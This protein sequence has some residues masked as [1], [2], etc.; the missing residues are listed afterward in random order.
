[1]NN[2]VNY[3]GSSKTN[4]EELRTYMQAISAVSR[5]VG[6]RLGKYLNDILPKVMKY[7]DGSNED[8]ELKENCFQV[9]FP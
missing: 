3:I 5:S 9:R 7:C 6:Y 2:L 4:P 8:D 1:V